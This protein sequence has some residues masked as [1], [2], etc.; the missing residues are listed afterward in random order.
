MRD[1]RSWAP[2]ASSALAL[3]LA[4]C[5]GGGA[6]T[7]PAVAITSVKVMGDSL[8]DSGTFGYKFTVQATN[9]NGIDLTTP[10]IYPELVAN[11][12]GVAPLCNVYTFTGTTFIANPTQTGCTN[13]AIGGGRINNYSDT[14]GTSPQSIPLQLT[15][16]S[17]AGNYAATDLLIIDGG[18]NDAADLV[19]A[20]LKASTDGGASY[21]A[22][23]GTVLPPATVNAA[24]AGGAAGL[25]SV[26]G[27][28]LSALADN[29]YAS[30]KTSAL[31]KGAQRVVVLNMPGITNTPRFQMVLDSIGAAAGATARAQSE[32]LFKSWIVAFN[33]ELSTKFSGDARVI[34]V[35]FYTSFNDQVAAPTQYGL[36]NAATPACPITGQDG[37][38]LPTYT[39]ATCT[40]AALSAM[41]P[42]AGATGGADWWK[43]YAFSDSF[44]PTPQAHKNLAQLISRSLSQAGWL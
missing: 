7:T 2:F 8:A 37:S 3:L 34:V 40:D 13:S 10:R 14:T 23:L 31:D 24:L 38:G 1:I 25:A 26:G 20:Y 5:G 19:G 30:I 42:P 12:Y 39:F 33:T 44:H 41:T 22:L 9:A 27:T 21:A 35:D 11:S 32:A 29:F 18:G 6:D 4:S 15:L 17:A 36:T 43:T 16:A 28:Y